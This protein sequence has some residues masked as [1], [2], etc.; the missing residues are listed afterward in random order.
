MA[1]SDTLTGFEFVR[2]GGLK[3]EEGEEMHRRSRE[4]G[5]TSDV[6]PE[7]AGSAAAA[8]PFLAQLRALR[9][10]LPRAREV[11]Y[12]LEEIERRLLEMRGHDGGAT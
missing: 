10:S 6:S 1:D 4:T 7:P 8:D 12:R 11:R 2:Y 9:E 5:M 3:C